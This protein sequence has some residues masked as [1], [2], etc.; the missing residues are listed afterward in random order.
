[1]KKRVLSML[2]AVLM[3]LTGAPGMASGMAI[4]I[5]GEAAF[6]ADAQGG[7]L[8]A[9]LADGRLHVPVEA[10]GRQLGLTVEAD[11]AT[12]DIIINGE[13]V[14]LAT[15]LV[16]G[17]VYVPLLALVGVVEDC[18][19]DLQMD[20]YYVSVQGAAEYKQAV[21]ALARGEYALARELFAQA[22]AYADAAARIGA[23][24]YAEAEDMLRQGKYAEA[25]E[26]FKAAG[27][28]ADAAA[29]VSEPWYVQGQQLQAQGSL[30]EAAE[31]Y[32]KAGQYRDAAELA[33]Q[34]EADAVEAMLA[35][36]RYQEAY[37]AY[38]QS[39][40]TAAIQALFYQMAQAMENV[41]DAEQAVACYELAGDHAD[42]AERILALY[43]ARAAALEA[44][45][46]TA[47][48][49]D[50]YQAAAGYLDAQEKW[51]AL[52][53]GLAK[54]AQTAQ[55]YDEAYALYDT[56]RGY[57]DVDDRLSK[58]SNL[59]KAAKAAVNAALVETV[60]VGDT[61]TYGSCVH[62]DSDSASK[63]PIQWQVLKK[64]GA[65]VLVLS[66]YALAKKPFHTSNTK[67]VDWSTCSLRT[68]LNGSFMNNAFTEA[69]RK[70]IVS[71]ELGYKNPIGKTEKR[72]DKI[73]VLSVSE[74]ATYHKAAKT[75]KTKNGTAGLAWLRDRYNLK[76]HH[77]S[78]VTTYGQTFCDMNSTEVYVRPA[79]WLN[80]ESAAV[81][82]SKYIRD[83]NAVNKYEQIEKLISDGKY[84][85][86]M[87]TLNKLES[88]DRIKELISECQYQMTLQSAR[89][90][91]GASVLPMFY[92]L[93]NYKNS[94]ALYKVM[95][96]L[97]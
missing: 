39:K 84:Q 53:Y 25:V 90:G 87:N 71:T 46:K 72:K 35:E 95:E 34:L 14:Q 47:D 70:A 15:R 31:A 43:Y 91:S 5:N 81:D 1:M 67:S 33:A 52:T 69:E 93:A 56:I 3:L 9:V 94:K 26:A 41:G 86:A 97:K 59:K 13:T 8:E 77:V 75:V 80:L 57:S 79:M 16:D 55:K 29:R 22:G 65:K 37:A 18:T 32:R 51:Q 7:P 49:I 61:F 42:A 48:A 85:A 66:T 4:F 68:W 19:V 36:G 40:N 83:E 88:N 92:S 63:Q 89:E 2:L 60:E 78:L 17:V 21:E 28:Y 24:H 38:A 20:G 23:T 11:P 12:G 58:N 82:W 50:A 64:D 73:F 74:S 30:I 62:V 45:G 76:T 6:F 44:E 27:D 96:S 10:M 54:K